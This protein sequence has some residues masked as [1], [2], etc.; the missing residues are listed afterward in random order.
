MLFVI[1]LSIIIHCS[2]RDQMQ[3]EQALAQFKRGDMPIL[4]ATAVAARG[5]DIKDV[6]HVSVCLHFVVYFTN[7]IY[8]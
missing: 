8:V 4:V 2:D 3:R 7:F 1:L 5:L 6:D